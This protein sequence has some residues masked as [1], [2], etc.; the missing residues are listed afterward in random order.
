MMM[1]AWARNLL[2]PS[3]GRTIHQRP[4][5]ARLGVES[6]EDRLVLSGNPIYV[7][8][9]IAS[10]SNSPLHDGSSWATAFDNLQDALDLAAAT[11][12]PDEIWIAEGTYTPSRMYSPVD[13]YSV[14]VPG[15][16]AGQVTDNLKTFDLPDEVSLYGG[17]RYG[18]PSLAQRSPDRYLTV[19]SGDL[20]GNDINDPNA[21]GYAASKADN[22]WHIVTLG[23]DV[24]QTGVRGLLDGLHIVNGHAVG[25]NNGGTL[26]PF[27]WGHADGGGV[28]SIFG[29]D[30]TVNNTLFQYNFANSDGGGLFSDGSDLLVTNS[31]FL[32][33][34]ALIRAGAL[35]AL[36]DFENGVSHTSALINCYFQDN[37][38]RVFGGAV[39]A[40]GAYQG[41]DSMMLV[42][43][44]TFV[45]NQA[46]EGGAIVV[47][48]LPVF[49]EDSTF[50]NNIATVTAGALATT[51]VVA[52]LVG[53]PNNFVTVISRC[54]FLENVCK[55]DPDAHEELNNFV[56]APGLNFGYGGGA[57]LAYM[58]GYLEVE[59]SFFVRN[60]T[61]NGEGG[62]ILNGFASANLFGI[63]AFDVSTTVR[64]CMFVDNQ[65]W[66]GNGG[67]IASASD[68]LSPTSTMASTCLEVSESIFRDN[69]AFGNGGAVFLNDS[70]ATMTGN[71]F[72]HN[73]AAEGAGLYALASM[74][75][76]LLSS[77][78]QAA[79]K[80]RKANRF[81]SSDSLS[82]S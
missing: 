20:A 45:H 22:A 81:H 17:F 35:E 24:T 16:A 55:A 71:L 27:I 76:S 14:P 58:N 50:I 19:L 79:E 64:G 67:A 72:V 32:N 7:D 54:L 74:V 80:L 33:N 40:E 56:G 82:L 21:P 8:A 12:G 3:R 75:N 34:R 23:N 59:D 52:T 15:G 65:A 30:L 29:S 41:P 36:N 78:P 63:S 37:T 49:V 70:T 66:N 51:N 4:A 26:S 68:G 28:Y 57:L 43:G 10:H 31:T 6:L 11:S 25:P 46:A 5:R 9:H 39:V 2:T 44:C 18:A 53:A 48:T 42:R 13:A 38:C 69:S 73:R 77:D 47:D 60:V 62:A 1:H 61:E